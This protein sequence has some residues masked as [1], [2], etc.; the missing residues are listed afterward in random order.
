MKFRLL[1]SRV[2]INIQNIRTQGLDFFD[3]SQ[4]LYYIVK[5][6]VKIRAFQEETG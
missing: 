3:D 5:V 1:E 6:C 2:N 4:Y